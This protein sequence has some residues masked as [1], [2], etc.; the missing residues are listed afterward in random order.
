M[1]SG[2]KF[3]KGKTFVR[4]SH[5]VHQSELKSGDTGYIDGYV[6]GADSR[7]YAV[8]VRISDGHIDCCP[9]TSI[10]AMNPF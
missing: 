6:N 8:I 9:I 2:F 1:S 7:P 4:I 10:V 3:I 5:D